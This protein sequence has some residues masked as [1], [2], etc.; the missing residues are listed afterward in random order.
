MCDCCFI[1]ED[2]YNVCTMCGNQKGQALSPAITSFSH[3]YGPARPCYSRTSRFKKLLNRIQGRTGYTI[4]ASLIKHVHQLKPESVEEL[5]LVLKQWTAN[6]K[7]KP[8][9]SIPAIWYYCS[10]ERPVSLAFWE[11][12]MLVYMFNLYDC[13]CR[14]DKYTKTPPYSFLLKAFLEE[15]VMRVGR[16][17]LL[18]ITRF[19]PLMRCKWRLK[20]YLQQYAHV[21]RVFD[22]EKKC[23]AITN[24]VKNAS[25]PGSRWLPCEQVGG[26][27]TKAEVAIQKARVEKIE[28]ILRQKGRRRRS[29]TVRQGNGEKNLPESCVA[30]TGDIWETEA[31]KQLLGHAL[32]WER[33][34]RQIAK[35]DLA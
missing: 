8:Y 11:E 15:P 19:L 3:P 2:G 30:G 35:S 23:I 4:E 9:E 20:Y 10:A 5:F 18:R 33:E 29:N 12:R 22:D 7:P 14:D 13:R 16:E 21:R 31:V 26:S 17:R 32:R 6:T 27:G 25:Y 1:V 24:T 34:K 28:T